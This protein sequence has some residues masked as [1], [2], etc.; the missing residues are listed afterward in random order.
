MHRKIRVSCPTLK[1]H[2]NVLEIQASMFPTC[3]ETQHVCVNQGCEKGLKTT[4]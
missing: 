1:I 4:T 2:M 3:T